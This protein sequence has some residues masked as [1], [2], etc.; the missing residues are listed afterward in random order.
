MKAVRHG[1]LVLNLPAEGHAPAA[2]SGSVYSSTKFSATANTRQIAR[3]PVPRRKKPSAL[4][5]GRLKVLRR[6][7]AAAETGDHADR[8]GLPQFFW[9]L[10]WL[11]ATLGAVAVGGK[12]LVMPT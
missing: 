9:F 10:L 8:A 1:T 6:C 5:A 12:M 4:S 7:R 2:Y 3:S 11:A